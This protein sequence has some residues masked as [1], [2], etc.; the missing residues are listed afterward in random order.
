MS[1]KRGDFDV[2]VP[3]S[4]TSSGDPGE[5]MKGVKPIDDTD[6]QNDQD[7]SQ[8][9]SGSGKGE[10]G[11]DA[12][13]ASKNVIKGKAKVEDLSRRGMGGILS[14]DES[15][16]LQK[17]L[18]VPHE[19]PPDAKEIKEKVKKLQPLLD[20][21]GSTQ[22][23]S[24]KGKYV[25][26]LPD[27]IARMVN[28][29]VDWKN[30]LKKYIGTVIGS[31]TEAIMPNRRFVS[32][33]DY[34]YGSRKAKT[35]LKKCVIA[36]DVSG[37]IGVKELL[38]MVNEV[39]GMAAAK[40]LKEFEIVYFDHGIQFVEKLSE[41]QA[42]VYKPKIVGGGGTSFLEP[43]EYMEKINKKGELDLAVFMT[44]GY[45]NLNL[46]VPKFKNKFIWM[47]LDNPSFKAPFGN[48]VVFVDVEGGKATGSI[49]M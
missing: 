1:Y 25:R 28:P 10:E 15:A 30:L 43:L 13:K 2:L 37:S 20:K 19:S 17:D 9:G 5:G 33:G 31:S 6:D 35:K 11:E 21:Q 12:G 46:P 36:V 45:A 22:A 3:K 40:K 32:S 26:T 27:V 16:K 48:K 41:A 47:I 14:Q 29:I 24:G 49:G 8:K 18:G 39:K 38:I 7:D 44:D 4:K 23:G 42:A 34:V